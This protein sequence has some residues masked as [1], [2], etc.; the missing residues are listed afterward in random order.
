MCMVSLYLLAILCCHTID[1]DIFAQILVFKPNILYYYY[2]YIALFTKYL[3]HF[4]LQICT[5]AWSVA[6]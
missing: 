4:S 6:F 2:Y 3:I 5:S 1:W